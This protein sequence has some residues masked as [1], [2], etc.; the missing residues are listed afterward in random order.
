MNRIA[1]LVCIAVV[2]LSSCHKDPRVSAIN[3]IVFGTYYNNCGGTCFHI[4]RIDNN[5]LQK[6]TSVQYFGSYRDFVFSPD[7]TLTQAQ[8]NSVQ[9]L[10]DEVPDDMLNITTKVYGCPDCY[11]QGG[12]YISITR[13]GANTRYLFDTKGSPDEP[14]A[15]K[16]YREKIV[17]AIEQL[18]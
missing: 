4:Y 9:Y 12:I 3:E 13:N 7:R 18:P 17:A 1:A 2:A 6:D 5:K 14:A 15:Y 8:Y 16:A 11:D 10:V